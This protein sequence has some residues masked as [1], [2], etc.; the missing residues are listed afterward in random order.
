[1]SY[2]FQEKTWPELKEYADKNALIILPVGTVEEHSLYLP[3]DTDARIAQYLSAQIAEEIQDEIPVLVMPTV[4]SGYTPKVVQEFGGAMAVRPQIFVEMIH[5]ICA[6]IARMGF[7]KLFMLD[8]H[9]QHGPMLN[10][11]T[12]LIADEFGYYWPAGMMYTCGLANVGTPNIDNGIFHPQHGRV[13]MMPAENVTIEK[14]DKEVI[15]RG[16]VRD[17]IFCGYNFA[18]ERTIIFPFEGNEVTI[19]DSVTNLEDIPS[20]IM[21]LYHCNFGYPLLAPGAR[22]VKGK[23]E[24]TDNLGSGKNPQNCFVVDGAHTSKDEEVYCHTNTPDKDGYGYAA[25]INDGLSLGCYVKYK[26]DT[27]PIIMQW[28]NFCSYDYA[29]GLE[30]SNSYILGR[31]EERENG[32]LPVLKPHETKVYEVSIGILDGKTEISNF[33]K[34]L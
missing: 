14:T 2:L 19:R 32:T 10:M 27:L 22:M 8:C 6:S 11:V 33:E 20:E 24:I 34:L 17:R 9:G 30:P 28:K 15:V 4:W 26:M 3:V 5:D 12:K 31:T 16:T 23:G 21:I 18:L 29:M 1:M 25:V 7:S 13:G